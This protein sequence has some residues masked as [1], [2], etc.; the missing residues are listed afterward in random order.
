MLPNVMG[1]R[2]IILRGRREEEKNK[3]KEENFKIYNYSIF[4]KRKKFVSLN[5]K[6]Q[7][8]NISKF[9][10][11]LSCKLLDNY[12]KLYQALVKKICLRAPTPNVYF[13]LGRA[14]VVHY[15]TAS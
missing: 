13:L 5:T 3:T 12:F 10:L 9:F 4:I 14:T 6:S 1:T 11:L 2:T 15:E 8:K 7:I